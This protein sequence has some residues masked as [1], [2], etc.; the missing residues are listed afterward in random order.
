MY[1]LAVLTDEGHDI[2]AH[3]LEQ[4]KISTAPQLDKSAAVEKLLLRWGVYKPL[5]TFV[6]T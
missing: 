1:N 5:S 2:P 6:Y 3:V 4:M